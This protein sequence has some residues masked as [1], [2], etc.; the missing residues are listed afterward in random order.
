MELETEAPVEELE[1]DDQEDDEE[2]GDG[3]ITRPGGRMAIDQGGQVRWR[4]V[5]GCP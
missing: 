3:L 4:I 2:L 5:N 1:A